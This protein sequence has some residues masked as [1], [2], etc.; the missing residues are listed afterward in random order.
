MCIRDSCNLGEIVIFFNPIIID[1]LP[2]FLY[3]KLSKPDGRARLGNFNSLSWV[4][5]IGVFNAINL[6]KIARI[7]IKAFGNFGKIVVFSNPIR[8]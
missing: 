2:L 8:N 1:L 5:G 4:K 3:F 7:S 6:C